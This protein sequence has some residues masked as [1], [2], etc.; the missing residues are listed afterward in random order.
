MKYALAF[1]V[2]DTL[3]DTAGIFK[4]LE[5]MIGEKAEPFMV[6]WRQKQLEYAFRRGLMNRYVD[7]TVCTKQALEFSCGSFDLDLSCKQKENLMMEYTNLPIFPDVKPSLHN[8]KETGHKLFALS[9]GSKK[10]IS[11][12]LTKANI[13]DSFEDI[14]SVEDVK[15]FK[16]NPLIYKYFN[17][18]VKSIPSQSWLISA[19]SFDV[20]GAAAYG[21]QTVW[22]KRSQD[23]IFDPW[24]FQPTL[25]VDKLTDLTFA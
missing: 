4:A 21:M 3:I 5:Q 15:T 8:L 7:F 9:N 24:G 12:L 19:N 18:I 14:I 20:I 10:S 22:V 16:P 6:T 11:K 1:D 17:K 23:L 25:I 13:R 2:Y